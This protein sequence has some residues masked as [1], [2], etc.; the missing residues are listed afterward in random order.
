[1]RVFAKSLLRRINDH[2]SGAF[3]PQRETAS[4]Y[5]RAA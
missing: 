3:N 4:R 2:T 5:D 1:M